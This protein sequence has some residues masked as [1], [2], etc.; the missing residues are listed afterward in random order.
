MSL[1]HPGGL[2]DLSVDYL[3]NFLVN[4]DNPISKDREI[5]MYGFLDDLVID[6]LDEAVDDDLVVVLVEVVDDSVVVELEIKI[7]LK[8]N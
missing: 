3:I 5:L 1:Q 4:D 2:E 6:P 7:I 8:G